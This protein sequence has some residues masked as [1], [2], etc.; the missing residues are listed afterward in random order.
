M[1]RNNE[2]KKPA[3]TTT[4]TTTMPEKRKTLDDDF[5]KLMAAH[6]QNLLQANDT[7]AQTMDSMTADLTQMCSRFESE[8]ASSSSSSSAAG[9]GQEGTGMREQM[10]KG[11]AVKETM[12]GP[13]DI[14]PGKRAVRRG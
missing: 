13:K 9:G 6:D 10:D 5:Y 11:E 8:M 4:T 14:A 7:Y 3:T 2:N 1:V 12:R